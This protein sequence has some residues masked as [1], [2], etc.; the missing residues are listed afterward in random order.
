MFI[1]IVKYYF[2]KTSLKIMNC[3]IRMVIDSLVETLVS[4]SG[5]DL[6]VDSWVFHRKICLAGVRVND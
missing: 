4:V 3:S 6:Y 5:E 2:L 1:K